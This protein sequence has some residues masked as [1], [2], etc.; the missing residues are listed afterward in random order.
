MA[1]AIVGYTGFVG[2]NLLKFYKFDYFYNSSNFYEASNK[3]YDTIFFCGVPAVKWYANKFP[4]ED[5]EVIEKI[6]TILGTLKVK[7]IVVIST[8][9][10][11]ECTDSQQN[12]DYDCDIMNN[13][14]YGSNRYGFENFIKNKFENYHIIRLPALFGMGLKKNI[15]YDLIN[16]NQID[17]IEK[18]TKFQWYDLNWLKNDIDI[19]INN[20]IKIC[21]LFTEPLETIE[22]LKLFDD[23][24]YKYRVES[25]LTYDL[26]TKY[27]NIFNSEIDGYIRNKTTVLNNI[28]QYLIFNKIDKTILNV[29]NICI[30]HITQ[31]Q[32]ACILKLFGIKNI[33]I[34]PTTLIDSWDN[35]SN[36]NFDL[37]K[38][39]DLNIYSLQSITYGLN[40]NIFDPKSVNTLLSHIE[41]IIDCAVQNKVK[42][43]VFGCPKNRKIDDNHFDNDN[44]NNDDNDKIFVTFFRKLGDYI[45][46]NDLH[47]CIENNSKQYGCNYLNSID[48]IGKIVSKIN[49]KNI[50]MMIDI[51]NAIMENDNLNHLNKYTELL[52]NIDIANENMKPFIEYSNLHETFIT[53]LKKN[54]YNKKINLEMLIKAENSNDELDILNNSLYNFIN[55]MDRD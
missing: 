14:V 46:D 10:V 42:I 8:I 9:D 20:K 21:N 19:I 38:K 7:K 45:G 28:K 29:S 22:I 37:F 17:K 49:H 39:N 16:N 53:I 55:L 27:S 5:N 2:S 52:Y 15:I 23:P 36:I 54:N 3:E 12:E 44:D 35:L 41:K 4:K 1:N 32:F 48:E 43:L 26:K 34:A 18:N 51:G 6:Q 30:K 25:K 50:K 33:Q 31:F 47:I 24:L 11:Y 40:D 13:H